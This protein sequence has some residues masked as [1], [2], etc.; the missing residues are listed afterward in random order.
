MDLDFSEEQTMLREMVRG[1]CASGASLDVVRELEDDP[2]GFGDQFWKQ[3]AE[4]DLIGLTVDEE[5]GGSGMS[6]L[7]A[8]IVYEEFGRSLAPSPHFASA[9]M[10]AGVL[11]AGRLGRAAPAPGCRGSPRVTPSSCRRGSSPAMASGRR[12]SRSAPLPLPTATDSCS[13]V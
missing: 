4:L 7:E 8:A 6:L 12:A 11:A 5:Y 3:L 9:V 10:S 13:T 2:K 1:V